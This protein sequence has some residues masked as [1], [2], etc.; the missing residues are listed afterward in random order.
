MTYSSP[1]LLNAP[2]ANLGA[3]VGFIWGGLCIFF[4]LFS[5]FFVPELK[6]RSLEETEEMFDTHLK[7]GSSRITRRLV[8]EPCSPLRA[9]VTTPRRIGLW[10]LRPSMATR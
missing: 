7:R 6:G 1:Y 9:L 3:K 5:I 2:Y 4:L 10:Q 8:S